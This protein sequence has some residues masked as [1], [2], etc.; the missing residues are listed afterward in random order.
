[1]WLLE[2]ARYNHDVFVSQPALLAQY[3]EGAIAT[4]VIAERTE[5]ILEVLV[6]EGFEA[7]EAMAAY[8]LVSSF[9]IGAAAGAHPG[10]QRCRSRASASRRSTAAS[11]PSGPGRA[12][13]PA[14]AARCA[15]ARPGQSFDDRARTLLAGMAARRGEDWAGE[16]LEALGG[17]RGP[18][19]RGRR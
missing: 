2:W 13:A 15:R 9:A 16:A 19:R 7:H 17:D 12:G 10:A 3:L 6:R 11:S 18:E 8:E 4:E 1:V 5:R 14:P